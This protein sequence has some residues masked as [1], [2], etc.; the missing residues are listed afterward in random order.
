MSIDPIYL[1]YGAIFLFVLLLV[2]GVYYFVA[3]SRRAGG[4]AV[5]RRLQMLASG[6]EAEEVLS[7]LRRAKRDTDS[8]SWMGPLA[9]LDRL[10]M[11]AGYTVSVTR[12][13]VIMAVIGG[14]TFLFFAAVMA[15]PPARSIVVALVTGGVIPILFLIYMKKRRFKRFL[16]QF[17][18]TLDLVV[19]SLR[20]G[21]PVSAAMALVA[22]EMG[23]PIGTEFGIVVDEMT[24]GLDLHDAMRNMG[25][26]IPIPDLHYL[27][28]AINIQHGVGGNLANVLA[29]LSSVV[30]ERFNMFKRIKALSAEGR[31]SAIVLSAL[32]VV[33]FGAVWLLNKKYFVDVM[34]DPLFPILIGAGAGM[35]L[36]GVAIIWKMV[37]FRV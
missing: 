27:E 3:D 23:D 29:G 2:E 37:N 1:V 13:L 36:L 26:R 16:E 10:I 15:V 32:P 28:V 4:S 34:D 12:M 8:V 6:Q 22:K 11:Q 35:L 25:E 17:P 21:H 14:I 24:Y 19:R 5:N 18:D 7:K 33:V 9:R 20:A 30:R 31:L